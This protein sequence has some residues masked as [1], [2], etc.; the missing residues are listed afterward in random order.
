MKKGDL[1]VFID[2]GDSFRDVAGVI[3]RG[4]YGSVE[5]VESR[6]DG[7]TLVSKETKVVDILLK[8]KVYAKIPIENLKVLK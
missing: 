6:W 4:P 2:P 1:V 3:I 5:K 7:K 8:E